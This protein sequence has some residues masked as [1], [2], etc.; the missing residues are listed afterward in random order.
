[1]WFLK[2]CISVLLREATLV[3][4]FRIVS[5]VRNLIVNISIITAF[6][7]CKNSR[8]YQHYR[9]IIIFFIA[10]ELA[11]KLGLEYLVFSIELTR[12]W[13]FVAR[14]IRHKTLVHTVSRFFQSLTFNINMIFLIDWHWIRFED[15]F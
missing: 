2:T 10:T 12:K 1:M 7:F 8:W 5:P 3:L 4:G 15:Y 9:V 13:R 6:F 11:L 14:V